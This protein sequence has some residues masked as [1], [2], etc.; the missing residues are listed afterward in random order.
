M[1]VC[2]ANKSK[3]R[4]PILSNGIEEIVHDSF[5]SHLRTSFG[6][7]VSEAFDIANAQPTPDFIV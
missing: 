5:Q 3:F 1:I 2:L 4:K 7:S 6:G